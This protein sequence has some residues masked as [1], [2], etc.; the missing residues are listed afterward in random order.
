MKKFI[1]FS[2]IFVLLSLFFGLVI[3]GAIAGS[4]TLI[5]TLPNLMSE[6]FNAL[7][8]ALIVGGIPTLFLYLLCFLLYFSYKLI[9]IC[10]KK[11][12]D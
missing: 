1:I 2:I 9:Q 3:G 10:Y 11:F 8:F 5:P 6:K 4:P 7:L 12:N